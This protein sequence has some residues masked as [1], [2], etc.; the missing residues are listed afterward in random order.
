MESLKILG[1]PL[2]VTEQYPQ[3]LGGTVSQIDITH[4]AVVAPKTKFSMI[5][6]QIE[7]EVEKLFNGKLKCAI[8]FGVEV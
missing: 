8:L 7:N 5:I 3:G 6:P 1:V 4:A 2:L